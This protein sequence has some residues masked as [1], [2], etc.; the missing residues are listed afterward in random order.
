MKLR[1]EFSSSM[2][3]TIEILMAVIFNLTFDHIAIFILVMLLIHEYGMDSYLAKFYS[4]S[5]S[6]VLII[7][8][9][10]SLDLFLSVLKI[11][12]IVET[13]CFHLSFLKMLILG[14]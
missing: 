2:K 12:A 6:N 1:V 8:V 14:I 13:Y 5:F 9:F 3:D 7:K 11:E 4:I 10:T